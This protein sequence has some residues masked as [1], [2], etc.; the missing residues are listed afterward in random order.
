MEDQNQP[1]QID[2]RCITK[3]KHSV[4]EQVPALQVEEVQSDLHLET[5]DISSPFRQ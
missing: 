2:A 3:L 5:P 4:G 1:Q